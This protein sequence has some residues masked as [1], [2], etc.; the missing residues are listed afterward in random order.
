MRRRARGELT[1]DHRIAIRQASTYAIHESR[2]VVNAI[3]HEAGSSAIF[4]SQP[5]ER[6]LRDMNAVSQQL[7]GRRAHFETVGQHLL[8]MDVNARNI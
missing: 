4:D 8:G 6:R 2:E 5:F 7:Q 3:Y 1:L